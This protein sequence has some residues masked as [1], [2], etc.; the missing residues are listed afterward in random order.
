MW[1]CSLLHPNATLLR[2]PPGATTPQRVEAFAPAAA[3]KAHARHVIH[4]AYSS[5][6]GATGDANVLLALTSSLLHP[7]VPEE[8][9]VQEL[10]A[11][12]ATRRDG[13]SVGRRALPLPRAN[14]AAH[15]I[16]VAEAHEPRSL[17]VTGLATQSVYQYYGGTSF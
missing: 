16:A 14:T 6:G 8:V 3:G 12:W 4:L 11:D 10:D 5:R 13:G 7:D 17:F 9:L 15:R 2:Y 1:V